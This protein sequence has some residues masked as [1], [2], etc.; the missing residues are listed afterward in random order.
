MQHSFVW[1]STKPVT[2]NVVDERPQPISVT[3]L[4]VVTSH[5]YGTTVGLYYSGEHDFGYWYAA[6]ACNP[7]TAWRVAQILSKIKTLNN[8][9]QGDYNSTLCGLIIALEE[10]DRDEDRMCERAK[11]LGMSVEE[12]DIE[13]KRLDTLWPST[14]E[15]C[16][17]WERLPESEQDR[18]VKM[19]RQAITDGYIK[20]DIKLMAGI[21][22]VERRLNKIADQRKHEEY[23]ILNGFDDNPMNSL[24]KLMHDLGVKNLSYTVGCGD[25]GEPTHF[26]MEDLDQMVMKELIGEWGFNS[27]VPLFTTEKNPNDRTAYQSYASLA[28]TISSINFGSHIHPK[29]VLSQKIMDMISVQYDRTTEQF[30]LTLRPVGIEGESM[31]LVMSIEQLRSEIGNNMGLDGPLEPGSMAPWLDQTVPK[32]LFS[33]LKKKLLHS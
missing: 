26:D 10:G 1:R 7:I 24:Q 4:P 31:D 23:L 2:F 3:A 8:S 20:Q 32:S 9:P 17:I 29:V 30:Q 22:Q 21:E 11:D 33:R 28:V 15:F 5:Y 14:I 19:V 16:S 25:F 18:I 12:L 27:R 6:N 13:L